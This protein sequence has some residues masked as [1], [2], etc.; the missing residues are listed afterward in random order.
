MTGKSPDRTLPAG[1]TPTDGSG[2]GQRSPRE[3]VTVGM[4]PADSISAT[5]PRSRPLSAADEPDCPAA[6]AEGAAAPARQLIPTA[7]ARETTRLD[8]GADVMGTLSE[9][10]PRGCNRCDETAIPTSSPRRLR[11]SQGMSEDRKEDRKVEV[12]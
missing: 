6:K 11:G 10:D 5:P 12:N 4:G 8:R 3:A 1:K 2:A 9:K 7:S